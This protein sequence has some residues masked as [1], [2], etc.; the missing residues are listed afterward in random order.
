LEQAAVHQVLALCFP[1][2]AAQTALQALVVRVV[3][4]LLRPDCVAHLRL[5]VA[6]VVHLLLD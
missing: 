2:L 3:R 4:V 5:P 6:Q 1:P